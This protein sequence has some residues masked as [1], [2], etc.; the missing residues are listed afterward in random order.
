MI[1]RQTPS[2]FCV[3]RNARQRF[4]DGLLGVARI[5]IFMPQME[6]LSSGDFVNEL[7][8]VVSGQCEQHHLGPVAAADS[9]HSG[10]KASKSHGS[11]MCALALQS[12]VIV[13]ISAVDA[14]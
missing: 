9:H 4:L 13:N 3:C 7:F 6:M 10:S 8:V 5:E 1:R 2:L 12:S 14:R 11:L